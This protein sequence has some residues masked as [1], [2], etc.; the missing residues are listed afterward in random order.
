MSSHSKVNIV[1]NRGRSK[2][3]GK[4][5][6]GKSRGRSKSRPKGLSCYYC[7]KSGHKKSECRFL[8]RDQKART[9]H[10]NQIDLKKNNKGGNTTVVASNDENV[11]LIGNEDT[12]NMTR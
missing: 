11:F 6:H 4:W 10:A 12:Q 8:K 9:V 7:G 5:S 2:D 1:E 3:Y